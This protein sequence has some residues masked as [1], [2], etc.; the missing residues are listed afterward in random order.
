MRDMTEEENAQKITGAE[1]EKNKKEKKR[2]RGRKSST[3]LIAVEVGTKN[4]MVGGIGV[5]SGP[6]H[7]ICGFVAE[8]VAGQFEKTKGYSKKIGLVTQTITAGAEG[9]FVAGPMGFACAAAMSA[10]I[11]IACE[12]VGQGL[13]KVFVNS[14]GESHPSMIKFNEAKEKLNKLSNKAKEKRNEAAARA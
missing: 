10:C 6:I 1:D 2:T 3:G 12:G 4:A 5:G 14:N 13:E 7:G 11:W 9:F 8:N